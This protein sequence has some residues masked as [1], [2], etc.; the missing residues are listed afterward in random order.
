MKKFFWISAILIFSFAL[1]LPIKAEG[2][3]LYLSPNSGSFF[4]G[5][6]F[7]VSIFINTGDE[8]INAVKADL[9]FDPQKL[10][11]ASPT[12]GKS[13]ISVWVAQPTYSNTEGRVSFQG[14]VPSPG[15]NTSSGLIS[16]ITFR[17]AAPGKAVI[18]LLDSSQALLDD[19]KGTNILSSLGNGEY[20]IQVPPPAGP[21]IYSS[22][23][24]DQNKWYKNSS[25]TFAWDK[26]EGVADFSYSLDHNFHTV[27]D[28]IAEGSQ[29]IV[30][31]TDLEDGIWYF[32]VKAKKAGYWG[33]TSHYVVQ[34]DTSPPAVFSLVFEP[35]LGSPTMTSREP[36]ISFITTDSLS[37]LNYYELKV[38]DLRKTL[39]KK[40]TA[41]FV[42][43]SSPYKLPPVNMGEYEIIVRA[44]D[45]ALNFRDASE[46]V[47]V[48]PT[49]ISFYI[50]KKGINLW[51]IF[52]SWWWAIIVLIPFAI[53]VLVIV[54]QWQKIYRVVRR[55]EK[56]LIK[57]KEKA[58]KHKDEVKRK[59]GEV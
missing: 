54:F 29:T 8:N 34:I 35:A 37:G 46:R 51:I 30:S 15:I 36:I 1:I 20:V 39:E 19:G 23:H 58:K 50:T 55:S 4:V 49:D 56:R 18:S 27:P 21:S 5:S 11:I 59:L 10:Q 2:A 48:I 44:Y 57:T 7:N 12:A 16:T 13:L 45:Q 22:T 33:G 25:P 3:S 17:A 26:E 9:K 52:L 53:F 38:I 6:T 42:E 47:D 43:V 31:Y 28:N 41:F 24:P 14:G 40:D 32:H